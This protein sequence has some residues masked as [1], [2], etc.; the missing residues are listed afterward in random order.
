MLAEHGKDRFNRVLL[1]K[2]TIE[3]IEVS[4]TL[5]SIPFGIKNEITI[6]T[7]TV[8]IPKEVFVFD[9]SKID[10]VSL[11]GNIYKCADKSL[12]PHYMYLFD[13]ISEKP[14]FHRPEFFRKL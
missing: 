10:T 5:G 4:S 12:T 8:K 13:I 7:L 3:K 9:G 11:T 1:D 2:K 6:Y 14:D